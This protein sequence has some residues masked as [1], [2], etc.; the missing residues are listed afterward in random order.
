MSL[1]S[2]STISKETWLSMQQPEEVK[3]EIVEILKYSESDINKVKE[4][5]E[6]EVKNNT[7]GWYSV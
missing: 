2:K 3:E 5:Y 7:R 4:S 1:D 6:A